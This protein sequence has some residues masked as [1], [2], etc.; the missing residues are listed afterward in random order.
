[1][2]IEKP[3]SLTGRPYSDIGGIGRVPDHVPSVIGDSPGEWGCQEPDPP[4]ECPRG[5]SSIQDVAAIHLGPNRESSHPAGPRDTHHTP[6][7]PHRPT[8]YPPLPPPVRRFVLLFAALNEN[9][10]LHAERNVAE[11]TNLVRVVWP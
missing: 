3:F 2:C 9:A 6:P 1:M 4:A 5:E 7:T 10:A 11:R 8:T